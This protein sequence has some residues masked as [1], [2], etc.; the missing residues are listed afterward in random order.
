MGRKGR[1]ET[2][3][4]LNLSLVPTELAGYLHL[5]FS[6]E[7]LTDNGTLDQILDTVG[8]LCRRVGRATA[9]AGVPPDGAGLG[10]GSGRPAVAWSVTAT[11]LGETDLADAYEQVM[12]ILFRLLFV[13]YA[14]DKDLLPYRTNGRYAD[15]SLSKKVPAACR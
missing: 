1:A 13:A 11:I 5:L 9:G 7:A 2:F 15:H 6:A 12:V 14:E 8:R 10:P 4:E 3:V